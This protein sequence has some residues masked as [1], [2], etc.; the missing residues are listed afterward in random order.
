M[1]EGKFDLEKEAREISLF[2]DGNTGCEYS[3]TLEIKEKI[4]ALC[5][6]VE[7]EA[8][9]AGFIFGTGASADFVRG[10]GTMDRPVNTDWLA[11]K[12]LTLNPPSVSKE[13]K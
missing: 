10:K 1:S 3:L 5:R 13:S 8:I 7:A 2:V 11:D 9:E 4:L 6:R 12:I